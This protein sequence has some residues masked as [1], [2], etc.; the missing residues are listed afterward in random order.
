MQHSASAMGTR[1][2]DLRV[3]TVP[4][5]P[6]GRQKGVPAT[7]RKAHAS[8]AAPKPRTG[9]HSLYRSRG[10]RGQFKINRRIACRVLA[11]VAPPAGQG[12]A[13]LGG[14]DE[15]VEGLAPDDDGIELGE[16]HPGRHG[17][18]EILEG[19][20][21]THPH[22]LRLQAHEVGLGLDELG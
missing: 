6:R 20:H 4:Q 2:F 9:A 8:T 18:D 16:V 7:G 14:G 22:H 19:L 13:V 3:M 1:Y 17:D 11:R 5:S 15:L 12:S 10:A 21:I